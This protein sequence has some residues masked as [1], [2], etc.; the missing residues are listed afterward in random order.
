MPRFPDKNSERDVCG[1][2]ATVAPTLV[3]VLREAHILADVTSDELQAHEELRDIDEAIERLDGA[4]HNDCSNEL[5]DAF[6]E[7]AAL[8]QLL[9]PLRE[10]PEVSWMADNGVE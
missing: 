8:R 10:L 5:V 7:A 3:R 9:Q 2:S 4:F 6:D 1:V